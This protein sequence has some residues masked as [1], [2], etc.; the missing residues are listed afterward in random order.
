MLDPVRTVLTMK[1][2]VVTKKVVLDLVLIQMSVRH[3]FALV[4]NQNLTVL[5]NATLTLMI[6]THADAQLNPPHVL[7]QNLTVRLRHAAMMLKIVT[8]ANAQHQPPLAKILLPVS[9]S[10]AAMMPL[11]IVPHANAQ[12][13]HHAQ[14][15]PVT[16]YQAAQ[17]AVAGQSQ[18]VKPLVIAQV[19]ANAHQAVDQ[20]LE[21]AES[22]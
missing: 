4:L 1:S 20:D 9:L 8:H 12:Q 6:V 7:N 19:H 14:Q 13:S 21:A 2:M 3:A 22:A 18:E 15:I 11:K 16:V 5:R 17:D 10:H